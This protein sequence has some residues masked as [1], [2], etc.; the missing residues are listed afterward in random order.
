[1]SFQQ[2]LERSNRIEATALDL[3]VNPSD[4]RVNEQRKI[5]YGNDTIEIRDRRVFRSMASRLGIPADYL[6]ELS[7]H[8]IEL[9]AKCIQDGFNRYGDTEEGQEQKQ[10]RLRLFRDEN[11][12]ATVLRG[13]VTTRYLPIPTNM[14]LQALAEMEGNFNDRFDRTNV[15]LSPYSLYIS[16]T[17][18]NKMEVKAVGDIFPGMTIYNNEMGL[19]SFEAMFQ[20][21]RLVCTNG[22]VRPLHSGD[23][24][25][26]RKIHLGKTPNLVPDYI[27]AAITNVEL[28]ASDLVPKI[29]R[30][31]A[32]KVSPNNF[33]H[34]LRKRAC[35][36]RQLMAPLLQSYEAEATYPEC[37]GTLWGMTNGITRLANTMPSTQ[38]KDSFQRLGGEVLGYE[39]AD[40]NTIQEIGRRYIDDKTRNDPKALF[41][42]MLIS[43]N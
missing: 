33:Y 26:S 7:V 3:D 41:N 23:G 15:E 25:S 32:T 34:G 11:D 39:D 40:L 6:G 5:V 18:R 36:Q 12:G 31:I 43:E 2:H 20:L 21:F 9:A 13:V 27:N 8:N 19:G 14:I 37:K 38:A 1:M 10:I 22:M 29:E 16:T 30:A 4:L 42:L 24:R 35:F 17:R 28:T